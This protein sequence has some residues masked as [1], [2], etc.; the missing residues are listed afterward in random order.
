MEREISHIKINVLWNV[1]LK[2][3]FNIKE[4]VKNKSIVNSV[5]I[6]NKFVVLIEKLTKITKN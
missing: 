6:N 2:I 1:N 5:M 4:S 3:L